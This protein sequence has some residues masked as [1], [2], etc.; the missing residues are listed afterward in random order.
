[1]NT[2]RSKILSLLAGLEAAIL[3][4]LGHHSLTCV[5]G[6]LMV[7]IRKQGEVLSFAISEE[8]FSKS[9]EDLV[10]EIVRQVTNARKYQVEIVWRGEFNFVKYG[11]EYSD[12]DAAIKYAK[13]VENMG[14]GGSVKKT[15]ITDDRGD[16]VW[17]YGQK[18]RQR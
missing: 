10:S 12:L 11:S 18:M 4:G 15:R 9:T 7:N 16:I 5:E 3:P 13:S 1:M 6:R 2:C 14:D 8:D 17:Q